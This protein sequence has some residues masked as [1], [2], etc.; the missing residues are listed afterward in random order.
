MKPRKPKRK[1]PKA[2]KPS[3]RNSGMGM[4]PPPAD[5]AITRTGP[6][7][8]SPAPGLWKKSGREM[9]QRTLYRSP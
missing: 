3:W 8:P 1:Q 2:P 5:V 9:M 6:V 7:E 4:R